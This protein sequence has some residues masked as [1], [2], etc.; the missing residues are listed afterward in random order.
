MVGVLAGGHPGQQAGR[1]ETAV[2]DRGGHRRGSDGLAG[3]AGVLRADVADDG[4]TGGFDVQ[5]FADILADLDEVLATWATGAAVRF[6]ADFAARQVGR[7]RLAAGAYARRARTRRGVFDFGFERRLVGFQGLLEQ[8]AL[9]RR[10]DF[11]LHAVAQ[12]LQVGE[13]QGEGLDLGFGVPEAGFETGGFGALPRGFG[14]LF[15][16]AG[17]EFFQ[18]GPARF[19]GA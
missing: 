11:A 12:S 18:R 6:V 3:A 5:L 19:G 2:D 7:Q 1:G 17:A 16:Q 14:G 13:F 4:E 8:V 10:E 9:C 15:V